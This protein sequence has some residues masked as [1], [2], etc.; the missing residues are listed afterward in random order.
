MSSETTPAVETKE[1]ETVILVRAFAEAAKLG[2]GYPWISK[3]TG[4]PE[5]KLSNKR[6]AIVKSGVKL[7]TLQRGRRGSSVNKAEVESLNAMLADMGFDTDD[8]DDS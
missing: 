4:I 1:S 3:K 5:N 2:E 7:P 8:S 6:S